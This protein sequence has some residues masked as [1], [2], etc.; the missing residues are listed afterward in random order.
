MLPQERALSQLIN[1]HIHAVSVIL[2][3]IQHMRGPF[4]PYKKFICQFW[5]W[6]IFFMNFMY[7]TFWGMVFFMLVLCRPSRQFSQLRAWPFG[8]GH[9]KRRRD[10]WSPRFFQ[11]ILKMHYGTFVR[12]NPLIPGVSKRT[13][14]QN[15]A[16]TISHQL[17]FVI[18]TYFWFEVGRHSR[19]RSPFLP[20]RRSDLSSDW[21]PLWAFN[22]MKQSLPNLCG[23][24]T[25]WLCGRCLTLSLMVH[26]TLK[27]CITVSIFSISHWFQ[28][29][30]K[31]SI[32][33]EPCQ[34]CCD[35]SHAPSFKVGTSNTPK[36][37]AVRPGHYNRIPVKLSRRLRREKPQLQYIAM[38]FSQRSGWWSLYHRD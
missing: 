3:Y 13:M 27:C 14:A 25:P 15:Q 9:R 37:T 6:N 5:W 31:Q 22:W 17:D 33:A 36:C 26:I 23:L 19:S 2:Q 18:Q 16:E 29:I 12:N 24:R 34:C 7:G 4:W 11:P 1:A 21:K 20:Y 38:T 10:C 8:V 32:C 30:W 28:V 35:T